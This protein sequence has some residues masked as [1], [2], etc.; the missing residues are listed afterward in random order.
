M[1]ELRPLSIGEILDGA[2]TLYRRH[3]GLFARLGVIALCVPVLISV[4][5]EFS[6]GRQVHFG[7]AFLAA[8]LQAIGSYFLTAGAIR[9]IS[10][11]YLGRDPKLGEAVTLGKSKI[12]PLFVVALGK[13]VLIAAPG[14]VAGM[15]L[16]IAGPALLRTSPVGGVAFMVVAG[17]ACLWLMIWI[18]CGYGVTTPV[19]VLE[20]LTRSSESFGR[21]WR[22]TRGFRGKIF[23]VSLV[24]FVII[25]VPVVVLGAVGEVIAFTAPMARPVTDVVAAVLPIVLTPVFSCVVTL[26]YYDLRVRR[27][28]FDL[29]VL[30]QTLGLA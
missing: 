28:A 4:Y 29:Q 1:A 3:F 16:A 24:A 10:E 18:A 8:I 15:V 19:V 21:S 23:L 7:L 20:R 11:S 25:Y 27:E 26:L 22:L 14:M 13:G 9:I 2:L 5:I 6:G 17:G 30:G 12:W